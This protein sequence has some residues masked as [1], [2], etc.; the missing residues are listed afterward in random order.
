M[1]KMSDTER[2]LIKDA[3]KRLTGFKR[4]QYQA[5]I[6]LKYFDGSTR[7]AERVM[8]W[9]R[10][11]LEKGLGEARTGIRCIDNYKDRGRKRTEDI[12]EGL[13]EDVRA[14]ADLRTQADPAVKSSLTYRAYA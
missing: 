1:S 10:E 6:T 2:E 3:S 9:G 12:I 14:I 7:K 13:E 5:S 8:G 4:R 11:S